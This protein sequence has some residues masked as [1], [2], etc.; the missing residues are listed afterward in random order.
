MQPWQL[1]LQL[2]SL[3]SCVCPRT[4]TISFFKFTQEFSESSTT[5]LGFVHSFKA[6]HQRSHFR[7]IRIG[8]EV[9]VA[10]NI[11]AEKCNFFDAL[12][13]QSFHFIRN[14]SHWSGTF[15]TSRKWNDAIRTHIVT[16]THNCAKIVET[17]LVSDL[18]SAFVT[19]TRMLSRNLRSNGRASHRHKF[20]PETAKH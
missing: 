13:G 6:V 7:A 17:K 18:R 2:F 10:V 4:K 16:A 15:S 14:G 20:R 11:L 9:T 8:S 12:G 5:H 19:H 1:F 3:V